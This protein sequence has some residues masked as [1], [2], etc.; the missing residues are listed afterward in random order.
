MH[1][2]VPIP[3]CELV[4]RT[5]FWKNVTY[6]F[7]TLL[8]TGFCQVQYPFQQLMHQERFWEI[9]ESLCMYDIQRS[10]TYKRGSKESSV[11]IRKKSLQN[12][13]QLTLLQEAHLLLQEDEKSYLKWYVFHRHILIKTFLYEHSVIKG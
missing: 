6:V 12:L 4:E 2:F 1:D 7:V 9:P 8:N 10:I 5:P 11:C 3:L 13:L